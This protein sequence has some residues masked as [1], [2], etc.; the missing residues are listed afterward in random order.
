MRVEEVAASS[1][2]ERGV[3]GEHNEGTMS[4]GGSGHRDSIIDIQGSWLVGGC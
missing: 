3:A 4:I 1:L 2:L